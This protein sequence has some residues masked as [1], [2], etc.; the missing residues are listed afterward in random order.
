MGRRA[1][2]EGGA[3]EI[4]RL[5]VI[6]R[7]RGMLLKEATMKMTETKLNSMLGMTAEELDAPDVEQLAA[8][9]WAMASPV[10]WV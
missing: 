8:A 5:R 6:L 10:S 2:R 4:R 9:S 1:K 3:F 7:G